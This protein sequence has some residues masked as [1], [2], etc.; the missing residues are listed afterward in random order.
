MAARHEKH[1]P[2]LVDPVVRALSGRLF[3]H[4]PR[5]DQRRWAHTYLA[6][7]LSTPGKKTVRRLAAATSSSPTAAQSLHQFLN[8]SP[9]D[10]RPARQETARWVAER[11]AS[12]AWHVDLAVIP[13]RGEYSVGVH[14]RFDQEA[15]RTI[16]CQVGIGAF[17]A[18]EHV[19]VPVDWRLLLPDRWDT[20]VP[21]RRR[22]RVPAGVRDRPVWEH[23]LDLAVSLAE[24]AMLSAAPIVVDMRGHPGV[25][26]LLGGL[27][28]QGLDF[29]VEVSGAEQV[30]PVLPAE[31]GRN[32]AGGPSRSLPVRHLLSRDGVFAGSRGSPEARTGRR[33][34][35]AARLVRLPRSAT[36]VGPYHR[37]LLVTELTSRGQAA[38][39]WL[40][41]LLTRRP[42][43][44]LS[45]AGTSEP[46]RAALRLMAERCGLQDFEGRSFPGWHHHMTMASAACAY[47]QLGG[48][49]G[50]PPAGRVQRRIS[51]PPVGLSA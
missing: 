24:G 21:L 3:A 1:L 27:L 31:A 47:H 49:L 40:S 39:Y 35:A 16:N 46:T 22:A 38:R 45:L 6:G 44:I 11:M 7:L 51:G 15:R 30:V 43:E 48:E 4:L 8:A 5:A 2:Q 20:D 25:N 29:V 42:E 37:L 18:A 36:R 12:W 34:G 13:K 50:P 19:A 17:L 33:S 28:D 14:R 32:P 10:W 26:S 9:W 41:S 23:V